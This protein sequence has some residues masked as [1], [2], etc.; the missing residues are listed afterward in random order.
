ML[1]RFQ[2]CEMN[3]IQ[4]EK[5]SLCAHGFRSFGTQLLGPFRPV[6]RQCM[7]VLSQQCR[8]DVHLLLAGK[9]REEIVT[10]IPIISFKGKRHSNLSSSTYTPPSKGFT[11]SQQHLRLMAKPLKHKPLGDMPHL[12]YF[13]WLLKQDGRRQRLLPCYRVPLLLGYQ[14]HY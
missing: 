6:K 11:I 9:Q 1:V 14:K 8:E 13:I 12:T 2:F 4:G 7:L 10:R 5:R 3:N